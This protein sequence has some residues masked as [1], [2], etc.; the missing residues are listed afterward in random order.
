[1]AQDTTCQSVQEQQSPQ[2]SCAAILD[3]EYHHYKLAQKEQW[4]QKQESNS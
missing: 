4:L 1:M 3:E 2:P